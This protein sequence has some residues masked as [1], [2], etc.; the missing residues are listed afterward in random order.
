MVGSLDT[1]QVGSV[2]FALCIWLE[3]EYRIPSRKLGLMNISNRFKSLNA[4]RHYAAFTTI[5][6]SNRWL[7]PYNPQNKNDG[8]NN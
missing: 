6:C 8:S 3:N 2:L 5:A 1:M 7:E 4:T